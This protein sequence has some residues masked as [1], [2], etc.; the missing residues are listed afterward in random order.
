MTGEI[1]VLTAPDGPMAARVRALAEGGRRNQA[2]ILIENEAN[3]LSA[4]EAGVDLLRLFVS[5]RLEG[6]DLVRDLAPLIPTT[7]VADEVLVELFQKTRVPQVFAIA[8]LP[9]RQRFRAFSARPG[10]IVVLDALDGPGNIGSIIRIAAAFEAGGVVLLNQLPAD[11]YRRGIV[12]A[13]AGAIFR[14]PLVPATDD[15][16]VRFCRASGT[17][18]VATSSHASGGFEETVAHPDRLALVLGSET[19]GIS[20][21]IDGVADIRCRIPMNPQV[22]SLNV[23]AAA[24]VLLFARRQHRLSPPAS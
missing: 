11:V 17:R 5:R 13:S 12:R 15:G 23:S 3:I 10:D 14:V 7:A 16:L 21:E 19:R 24:S 22:E 8:R 2:E 1:E 18:I 4:R 20:A 9:Q 6:S